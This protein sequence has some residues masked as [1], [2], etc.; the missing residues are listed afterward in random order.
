ML[1]CHVDDSMIV[2]TRDVGGQTIRKESSGAY[3]SRIKVSPECKDGDIH[4]YLSML[5]KIDRQ[6]GTLK[7]QMPKLMKKLKTLLESI[8]ER[9][10]RKSK[11]CRKQKYVEGVPEDLPTLALYLTTPNRNTCVTCPTLCRPHINLRLLS[12]L[13]LSNSMHH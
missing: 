1:C 8:G 9:A 3:G 13:L 5:I 4:E 6:A 12:T 7:F 10:K 11:F 2:C